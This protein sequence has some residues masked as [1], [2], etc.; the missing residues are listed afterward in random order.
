MH[1]ACAAARLPIPIRSFGGLAPAATNL[2]RC[3]AVLTHSCIKRDAYRVSLGLASPRRA[4]GLSY[5]LSPFFR[6]S[7]NTPPLLLRKELPGLRSGNFGLPPKPLPVE[8]EGNNQI[9]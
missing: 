4:F 9:T 1:I 5:F 3:A 8:G 7:E 2:G 6:A